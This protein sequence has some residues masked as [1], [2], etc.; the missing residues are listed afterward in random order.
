MDGD[1][2]FTRF[3]EFIR[4]RNQKLLPRSLVAIRKRVVTEHTSGDANTCDLLAV[5]PYHRT[6]VHV[7]A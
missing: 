2:V 6:I 5:D 7:Y 4:I 3:Q 1:N